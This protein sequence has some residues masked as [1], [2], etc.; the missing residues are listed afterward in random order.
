VLAFNRLCKI[1][2]ITSTNNKR[3]W[4]NDLAYSLSKKCLAEFGKMLTVEFTDLNYLEVR[5]GLTKTNFNNNRYKNNQNKFQD[6]YATS[7]YLLPENVARKIV[8]VLFDNT[9][10]FIEVAP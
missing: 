4:P 3:Y 6:I 2:N 5:L 9:I 7:N 10:K 8:D 1:V